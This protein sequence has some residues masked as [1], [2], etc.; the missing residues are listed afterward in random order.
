M[1]FTLKQYA[2]ALL[3]VTVSLFGYGCGGGGSSKGPSGSVI[4]GRATLNG[5]ALAGVTMTIAGVSAGTANT[6]GT[7]NFQSGAVANGNYTITPSKAGYSFSPP[8]QMVTV[9]DGSVTLPPFAATPVGA[10]YTVSGQVTLNGT[11]LPGVAVS[12]A[13][14]ANASTTTDGNGNYS[15]AG[16]ANGD[17]TV[18]AALAGYSFAPVSKAITVAGANV[19]VPAFAASAVANSFDI[20]GRITLNGSGVAGVSVSLTGAGVGSTTTD[21]LGNY[22][23]PGVQN[24][25]YTLLPALSGYNFAPASRP[26]TVNGADSAG[27]DFAALP[28]NGGSITIQF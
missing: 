17:C 8:S 6:D 21:A 23:F 24:G 7:G 22:S 27:Q 26:V 3:L 15:F 5:T 12:I 20:S 9:A 4:S 14:S 16:V 18:S 25:S 13:G 28:V 11:G 19:A 2:A 1:R 10:S